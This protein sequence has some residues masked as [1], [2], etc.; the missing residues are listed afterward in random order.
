MGFAPNPYLAKVDGLC[1]IV[2]LAQQAGMTVDAKRHGQLPTAY[3]SP[4]SLRDMLAHLVMI[5]AP[6]PHST[7]SVYS[8]VKW[9]AGEYSASSLGHGLKWREIVTFTG[10]PLETSGKTTGRSLKLWCMQPRKRSLV[11]APR[12]F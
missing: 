6:L 11:W 10:H 5:D 4:A 1:L 2:S 8:T 9:K 12:Y 7:P 3:A